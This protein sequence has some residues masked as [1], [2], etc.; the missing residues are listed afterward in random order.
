MHGGGRCSLAG[1]CLEC[2]PLAGLCEACRKIR[3]TWARPS[4][5]FHARKG[6]DNL[7]V[8]DKQRAVLAAP[9]PEQQI[10][11]SF[12]EVVSG[13]WGFVFDNYDSIFIT[14]E[15]GESL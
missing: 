2:W 10:D 4:A 7:Y 6:G 5:G 15:R 3:R 14:W 8:H 12:W 13:F 11:L 1:L 9:F